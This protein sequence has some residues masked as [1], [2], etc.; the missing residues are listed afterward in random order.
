MKENNLF[1]NLS[2]THLKQE[3]GIVKTILS[4]LEYS[5]TE[6]EISIQPDKFK[7]KHFRDF[8]SKQLANRVLEVLIR[9]KKHNLISTFKKNDS[10]L[11]LNLKNKVKSLENYKNQLEKEISKQEANLTILKSHSGKFCWLV[12]NNKT[13]LI[14]NIENKPKLI[15]LRSTRKT[16]H[17]SCLFAIFFNHWEMNGEKLITNNQILKRAKN[18]CQ[19]DLNVNWIKNT[20][21]NI[22]KC[23]I[24]E[25]LQDYIKFKPSRKKE[26]WIIS[27]KQ[28]Q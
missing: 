11:I 18:M 7:G 22:R 28:P 9:L 20:V 19:I 24:P 10:L 2:L 21:N 16:T 23:K 5:E 15:P 25:S 17:M 14:K 1:K 6:S 3:L 26:G 13:F 12:D 4:Q 27:I 8:S